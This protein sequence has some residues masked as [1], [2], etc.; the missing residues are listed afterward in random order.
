[1]WANQSFASIKS[2]G[3][4]EK[5]PE[6]HFLVNYLPQFFHERELT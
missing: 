5:L 6:M 2:S 4:S 1:M 3:N